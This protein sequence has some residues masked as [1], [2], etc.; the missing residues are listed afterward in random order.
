LS[1]K[2]KEGSWTTEQCRFGN[3]LQSVVKVLSTSD[4]EII[5]QKI[6]EAL[7]T[8]GIGADAAAHASWL[9]VSIKGIGRSLEGRNHGGIVP[10]RSLWDAEGRRLAAVL[11]FESVD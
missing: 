10:C 9:D 4:N 3:V 2:A 11:V 7:E 5:G 8:V 1:C 6:E